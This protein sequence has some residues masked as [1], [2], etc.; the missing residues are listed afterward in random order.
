MIYTTLYYSQQMVI[1]VT[2]KDANRETASL[3]LI[4]KTK[5][6]KKKT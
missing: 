5:K 1:L 4:D 6:Q 2:H 3:A